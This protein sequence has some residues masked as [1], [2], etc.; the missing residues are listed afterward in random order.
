MSNAPG[1]APD[2]WRTAVEQAAGAAVCY[3]DTSGKVRL[4]NAGAERLFGYPA[5]EMSGREFRVLY[6]PADLQAGSWD[7][8]MRTA[9]SS[10]VCAI[11]R[12]LRRAGGSGVA[13]EGT[14]ESVPGPS[15]THAGYTVI[16]R[17]AAA[18]DFFQQKAERLAAELNQFAFTVSHDLKGP[19]RSVK[20]FSELLGR[21]YRD[22][23]DSDASEYIGFIVDGAKK[24]EQ[25]LNDVL[26]YSQAGREDKTRPQPLDTSGVLLWALMNVD[27]LVKQTGG[28]ITY[29]PLP[30]V[31]ADQN[32]LAQ[33]FQQL[34][35]NALKFRSDAPP[36]VHVSARE[37]DDDFVEITIQDNGIG[38]EPEFHERIFGVFKRL[39]GADI[40]GTGIG[41]AISRRIVEAHGGRLTVE[42]APGKGS[43]FRFTLPAA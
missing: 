40:P 2:T 21:R 29:D 1:S 27:P 30:R 13:V 33:V 8:D 9:R 36:A 12:N 42:S 39:H 7:E 35:T 14:L 26:A 16:V 32:Q 6:S 31:C 18:R 20:S 15:G 17:E 22:S 37:A 11:V 10:S 4:W 5:A 24:M 3:L 19:L 41:L 25:L 23:L 38:I 43:T 28:A 34:L